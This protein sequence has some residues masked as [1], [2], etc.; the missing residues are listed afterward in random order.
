MNPRLSDLWVY[1][2]T[3]PL[4]G[5]TITLLAYQFAYLVYTRARYSPFANP[6]PIAVAI[7]ATILTLTGTPYATYFEGAK[8]V[9]FLLGPATV[10][11]A[12]PLYLQWDKLKKLAVPLL[13]GLTA[14]ALAAIVSATGLAWAL[15]A[16]K[17][18]ILSLAPKSVTMPIAMGI[19]E[20]IGGIPPLT[21]VMV[22]ATGIIG[23]V[24]AR[25]LLV[26][27]LH[28]ETHWIRG[29]AVG[30]AAHGIGTARAFLVSE[31]AG[32]FSGLAMGLNG[33]AT[34]AALPI[35]LALWSGVS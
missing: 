31:E 16:S 11:L 6:V 33:L 20:K 12:V 35:L 30:T 17:S 8:F 25:Q 3:T 23:A 5:L 28:I 14:G 19:S 2:A 21:A 1:L 29:L 7:L 4:L 27:L 26:G 22:M 15:G 32:A 34:S 13:A 9:H 24:I 18:T 10:A